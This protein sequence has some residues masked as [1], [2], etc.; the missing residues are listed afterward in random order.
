MEAWD[1]PKTNLAKLIY[2]SFQVK[3]TGSSASDS[4]IAISLYNHYDRAMWF[5]PLPPYYTIAKYNE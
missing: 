1:T 3:Y 2:M 5:K 4:G